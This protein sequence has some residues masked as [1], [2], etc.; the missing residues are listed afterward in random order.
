MHTHSSNK[1]KK[2]KETSACQKAEGNCFLGQ[3]R[4]SDGGIHASRD[5]NNVRNVLRNTK[6]TRKAIQN[7]RRGMMTSGLVLLHDNSHPHTAA[8]I[9][10][11]L[12]HFN[13][14]LFDHP[15]YSPALA[16]S[17]Y[18]LFTNVKNWF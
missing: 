5:H 6:I 17:D 14:E 8:R 2:F 12:E 15:P 11:L 7:K 3:K 18:H 10:T 9:R 4:S 16:P 1:P 13:L